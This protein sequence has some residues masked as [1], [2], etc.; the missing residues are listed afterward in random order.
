MSLSVMLGLQPPC[1]GEKSVWW[2]TMKCK[3]PARHRG[4]HK[5]GKHTWHYGTW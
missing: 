1:P 3:L 2:G 5:N 4:D